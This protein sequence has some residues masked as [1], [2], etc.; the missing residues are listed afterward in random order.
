MSKTRVE[1]SDF[2]AALTDEERVAVDE[3]IQRAVDPSVDQNEVKLQFFA[4][5]TPVMARLGGGH[6]GSVWAAL[7]KQHQPKQRNV[8]LM[9]FAELADGL[10]Y[11]LGFKLRGF[12]KAADRLDDGEPEPQ[13]AF[14]LCAVMG[15]VVRLAAL[16]SIQGYV[17]AG[18]NDAEINHAVMDKL[19]APSDGGWLE[20][21]QRLTKALKD[22][23]APLVPPASCWN[24]TRTVPSFEEYEP[25]PSNRVIASMIMTYT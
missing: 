7:N 4:M 18:K 25:A 3:I 19:R 23:E 20:V 15:V 12:L 24:L 21:A 22:A 10:P 6:P 14:E 5:A 1:W 17:K 9:P 11:P 2:E 16:I 13:F 8:Q